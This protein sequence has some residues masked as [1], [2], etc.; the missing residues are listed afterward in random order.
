M[1]HPVYFDEEQV[2]HRL[3]HYLPAQAPL[4]DFVHHNTLH[5]FQHQ[6]FF[7]GIH[8]AAEIFGYRISLSIREYRALYADG[9]IRV[10]I[11]EDRL[12]KAKPEALVNEWK[13]KLLHKEYE[14]QSEAR[15]GKLRL[16]WKK[17]YAFSLDDRVHPLLFRTLCSYL[18]QGIAVWNF[19]HANKTFPEALLE[20]EKNSFT[21][22]FRS[23][24][25]KALLNTKPSIQTLLHI[26]VGREELY[27]NYIYDQQFAH[28][29]WSGLIS[30]LEDHPESLLDERKI[31]L[32]DLIVLEL[33][34]EIDVLDTELGPNW[35]PLGELY[36][37]TPE[38]YW[39]PCEKSELQEVVRL[40]QEV[41]EWTYYDEVLAAIQFNKKNQTEK[42][43][44]SFHAAFCIDDRGCSI[45]RHLEHFDP[46]C[47][48]L[49]TPGFFN[50]AFYYK[51]L[52]GKFVTKLCPAPIQPQHLI[53]EIHAGG[54]R[55]KDLHLSKSTHGLFRAWLIAQ[56]AGFW[57]ALRLFR[58]IFQPGESPAMASSFAFMQKDS[59]LEIECKNPELNE[60]G[61]QLGF[62]I[63]E[64]VDRVE[65]FL[66]SMGT[67]SG[68]SDLF[69]LV[70]HGSS[71]VNNPHYSAYDCGACCGRPGSVNARV[72]AFMANHVV[73][74]KKLRERGIDIPDHTRFLSAIHDTSR[75]EIMFYDE[76]TLTPD[77][78]EKHLDHTATFLLAL[79][80]NAK[81]RSRRFESVASDAPDEKVHENVKKR[82]V[83]LFEPRPELNHATNALCIIG[84][85][86]FTAGIFLDRRAFMNSYD[87][88]SD[89]E[90]RY[91]SEILKA[92]T[93]VCGGINLEYYFSRVDNF[94]L[95]AGTKLPHNV[96]GLF[97]VANGADGDLRPGLPSQM[98]EVHD[99][100]RL[101]VI[102]EHDP[103]VVLKAVS[104]SKA[105]FEWFANEWIHLAVIH[106]Q[107][108]TVFYF[109]EGKFVLYEPLTD[110]IPFVR[111]L[112]LPLE[113][114]AE[115]LPV[116][117]TR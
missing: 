106:P 116:C 99:P 84:R 69:Y 21:G 58:N 23:P 16:A 48:T 36:R 113:R 59:Q 12:R 6:K 112:P 49:G 2:L 79:E 107:D 74:R 46:S 17:H 43:S 24:R 7:D 117:F 20:L 114:S 82:S 103:D 27:A 50:A 29:G 83:A 88:R 34:L 40:W 66:R 65:D 31:A 44:P 101:L 19:P 73:V 3:K 98:I 38:D 61:L 39:T 56:T 11:L 13:F 28:P 9:K 68:F 81:E 71:S 30:V 111:D 63:E 64:M 51:P 105:T 42:H 95:G 22:F 76:D 115:N 104:T 26:L 80:A 102:I 72:M 91:L 90:G 85:R 35:K 109:R 53:R 86:E 60:N 92:A 52:D 62:T 14:V 70:G 37:D 78:A 47:L 110:T 87:Y 89:P 67:L 96:M 1:H 15:V 41:L 8:Q 33:L 57:A 18:D 77:Q 93:P 97:A 100:V 94:K 54:K 32:S 55:K 4:K 5:A 25:V 75:D 10:D 108:K 45:R